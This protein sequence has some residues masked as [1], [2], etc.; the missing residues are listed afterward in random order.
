MLIIQILLIAVVVV[1]GV[2]AVWSGRRDS[3]V[4]LRRLLVLVFMVAAI[5]S[6]LVPAWLSAVANF[7][8]IGR[9]AD[10]LLYGTVLAFIAYVLA[11]TRRAARRQRQ[12][13][14]LVRALAL[15]EARRASATEGSR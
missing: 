11:D 1:L 7:V 3:H 10:L 15:A 5:V 12:I 14:L 2:L 6:I 13:T 9:G 8:G 4:A